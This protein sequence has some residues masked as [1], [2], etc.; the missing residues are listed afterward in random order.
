[1]L[2][3]KR[4][5]NGLLVPKEENLLWVTFGLVHPKNPQDIKSKE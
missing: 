1:M 3:F 2:F 5:K 4:K